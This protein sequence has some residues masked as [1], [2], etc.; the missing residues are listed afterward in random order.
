MPSA[1]Y[2]MTM[3]ALSTVVVVWFVGVVWVLVE[4]M[5]RVYKRKK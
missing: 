3:L 1:V 2:V 5:D 4:L